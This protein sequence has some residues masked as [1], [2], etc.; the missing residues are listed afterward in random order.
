[1]FIMEDMGSKPRRPLEP[2]HY[3]STQYGRLADQLS[4]RLSVGR[5]GQYWD[6]A[7]AESF[8][9]TFKTELLYRRSWPTRVRAHQAIFEW[10]EGWYNTRRWHS[11]LD[12]LSPAVYEAA[13]YAI[14][15][16]RK[17]A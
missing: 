17:V 11:T 16:D 9:A 14:G 15:P 4:V 7:V 2:G 13:A 3:T 1:M 10:I 6:N 12:Y 5:R 8:F